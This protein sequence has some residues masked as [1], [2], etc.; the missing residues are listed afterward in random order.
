MCGIATIIA[1]EPDRWTDAIQRMTDSLRH[2]GPD[3]GQVKALSACLLGHRRLSIIDLVTGDQ[4]MCDDTGRY[5]ITFNGEI[6]N[7][8]E[9]RRDLELSGACFR[10]QSDTEVLLQSY[11]KYGDDTPRHLNGQ[12][13]F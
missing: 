6:Y 9:L 7:Y 13:A 4:P 10:T 12:F 11:R 2:R 8:R 5:W 1:D 3:G